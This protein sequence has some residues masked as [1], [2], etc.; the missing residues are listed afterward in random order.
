MQHN[1]GIVL[2]WK[3]VQAT[4]VTIFINLVPEEEE[5]REFLLAQQLQKVRTPPYSKIQ[6]MVSKRTPVQG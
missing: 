6:K 3:A 1:T 5:E 4:V 2:A